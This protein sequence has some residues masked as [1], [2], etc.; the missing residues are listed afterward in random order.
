MFI[1]RQ[2]EELLSM[3]AS[4]TA[5]RSIVRSKSQFEEKEMFSGFEDGR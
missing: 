1:A 2:L 4:E 5:R 3:T